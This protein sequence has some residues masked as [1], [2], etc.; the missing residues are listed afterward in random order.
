[1]LSVYNAYFFS[2]DIYKDGKCVMPCVL[3]VMNGILTPL[4][5]I[6]KPPNTLT[7]RKCAVESCHMLLKCKIK[8]KE[9][10]YFHELDAESYTTFILGEF[11]PLYF[12]L[13]ELFGSC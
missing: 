6:V 8:C 5:I 13:K 4:F 10:K 1:M 11:L 12:I 9:K 3:E 2:A 7:K